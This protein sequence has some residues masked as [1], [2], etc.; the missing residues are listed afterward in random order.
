VSVTIKPGKQARISEELNTSGFKY[1]AHK[2]KFG[3]PYRSGGGR[4]KP[5]NDEFF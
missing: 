2:N 5:I 1:V 3:R 4:Y